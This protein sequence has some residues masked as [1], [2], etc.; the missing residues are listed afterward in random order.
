MTSRNTWNEPLEA[1]HAIAA[2]TCEHP[3]HFWIVA[4]PCDGGPDEEQ[5]PLPLAAT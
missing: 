5:N 2:G 4:D 3:R 1:A